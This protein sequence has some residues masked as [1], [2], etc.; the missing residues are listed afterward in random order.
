MH[1]VHHTARAVCDLHSLE[2]DRKSPFT[3]PNTCL[4]RKSLSPTLIV[5]QI[6]GTQRNTCLSGNRGRSSFHLLSSCVTSS[7]P[8]ATPI[9]S[10]P[11]NTAVMADPDE[12]QN[13]IYLDGRPFNTFTSL[14][15][16]IGENYPGKL[17]DFQRKYRKCLSS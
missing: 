14:C 1:L 9:S 4:I 6:I 12:L 11:A 2:I 16:F 15:A 7:A 5:C 10:K 13:L 3:Q 17:A 8:N